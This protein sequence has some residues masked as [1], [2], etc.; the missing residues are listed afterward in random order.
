MLSPS[1]SVLQIRRIVLVHWLLEGNVIFL[2]IQ[3]EIST[4]LG[5]EDVFLCM[6]VSVQTRISCCSKP[7]NLEDKRE[8]PSDAM[9]STV[10]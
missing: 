5:V 4:E 1:G 2:E 6:C 8:S 7:D 3:R 9:V 10:L